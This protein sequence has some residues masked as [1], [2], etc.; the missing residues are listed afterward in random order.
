MRSKATRWSVAFTGAVVAA[1]A[2]WWASSLSS[3]ER[4]IPT[5]WILAGA[6]IP[7]EH[8]ADTRPDQVQA[9]EM[10]QVFQD[11]A[12]RLNRGRD[13]KEVRW[14]ET[15]RLNEDGTFDI[16]QFAPDKNDVAPSFRVTPIFAGTWSASGS[17][18]VFRILEIGG[19]EVDPPRVTRGSLTR[20]TLEF[21]PGL[22]YRPAS[23]RELP[24]AAR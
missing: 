1:V 10:I 22:V 24:A 8:R 7:M 13:M 20:D 19:V 15:L 2:L 23:P 21:T 5:H 9:R 18:V 6:P 3:V 17:D 4:D 12:R 16:S 14:V 11:V